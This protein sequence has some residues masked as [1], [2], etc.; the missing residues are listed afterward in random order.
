MHHNPTPITRSA[1]APAYYL[2]RS[3]VV[4]QAA[5]RSRTRRRTRARPFVHRTNG[6][7]ID[8]SHPGEL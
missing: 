7:V 8:A 4:W 2:G 6:S 1:G 3:A 5:L